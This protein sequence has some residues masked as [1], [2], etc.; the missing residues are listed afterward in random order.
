MRVSAGLVIV[1]GVGWPA[2]GATGSSAF[3]SPKSSTFTVPSGR[4]LMLAGFRSRWMMPCSCAAF[5]GGG[6]L[7]ADAYRLVERNWPLGDAIRQRWPL[8]ELQDERCYSHL[9]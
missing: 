9:P 7:P 6:D 3:A 1:A 2:A 4:T 8:D 5:E